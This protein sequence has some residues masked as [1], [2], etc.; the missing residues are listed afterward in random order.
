MKITKVGHCCL[1]IEVAGKRIMTDPGSF[2]VTDHVQEHIDIVLITHEHGDHL[3]IDSLKEILL[4]N[5]KVKIITNGAVGKILE[6]AGIAYEKVEGQADLS[7][8]GI[9]FEACDAKHVKIFEDYGQVQNT[10]YFITERLF[11]PGDAYAD[12]QKDVEILVLPVAGPWCK[13]ADVINYAK[14]IAPQ[15]AFPVHDGLLNEVG[16]EIQHRVVKTHLEAIGID[17]LNLRSGEE[18]VIK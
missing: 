9:Y 17:F 6:E 1:L 10:G 5:P 14:T 7:I 2:T 4:I 12:P 13:V 18:V 11:Y 15:K 16:L 3:H 8:E